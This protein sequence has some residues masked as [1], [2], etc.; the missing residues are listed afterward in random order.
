MDRQGNSLGFRDFS[1]LGIRGHSITY[2]SVNNHVFIVAGMTEDQ[3]PK[4]Y[5]FRAGA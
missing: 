4:L 1:Q 3:T 2:D 5:K